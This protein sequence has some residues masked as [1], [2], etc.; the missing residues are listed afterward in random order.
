[1]SCTTLYAVRGPDGWT[2]SVEKYGLVD[3]SSPRAAARLLRR[4]TREVAPGGWLC[5]GLWVDPDQRLVRFH[6]C[7][8]QIHHPRARAWER[9]VQESAAW[10]GWD[11]RFAWGGNAEISE[12]L[13]ESTPP[14]H[15]A[16]KVDPAPISPRHCRYDP[17]AHHLDYDEEP[18]SY[19]TVT[20]APCL[21]SV[22]SSDGRARHHAV[23]AHEES[24]RGLLALG[25]GLAERLRNTPVWPAIEE[26]ITEGW[27]ILVDGRRREVGFWGLRCTPGQAADVAAR[28]PGWSVVRLPDGYADQLA[29]TGTD[30]APWCVGAG[31]AWPDAP[32]PPGMTAP[33]PS[34]CMPAVSKDVQACTTAAHQIGWDWL[35]VPV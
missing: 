10:T 29:R 21:V 30:P 11:V 5:R 26:D 25:P 14:L 22:I 34:R 7:H 23:M 27:G 18:V 8:H 31:R 33:M 20:D 6:S 16:T 3:V 4:P 24:A 15:P 9:S 12:L 13:G 1:M 2:F 32:P 35:Q 28:Y 17:T 19:T